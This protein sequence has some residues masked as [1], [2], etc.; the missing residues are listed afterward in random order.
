VTAASV[1][2]RWAEAIA[3]SRALRAIPWVAA[4]VTMTVGWWLW[5]SLNA[6]P[7][8]Y[9]EAAYLLQA[10]IFATFRWATEGRPL[11]EFF[12]QL[13]VF[14]TPKLVPKY[15]PGHAITMVPGI[16]LGLA[17]LVPLLLAGVAAWLICWLAERLTDRVT[18]ILTWLVWLT[19]PTV[20]TFMPS[21][22]S[23]STTLVTWLGGWAC[24]LRWRDDSRPRWLLAGSA[25]LAW[26][27]ITRPFSMIA[28]AVPAGLWLLAALYRRGELRRLIAMALV[29]SAILA[30]PLVWSRSVSGRAYP[31]PYSEYSRV[32]APWNMPGFRIDST[33]PLRPPTVAM[34]VFK[35][36]FLP[37]H[38]SHRIERLPAI[39][40]E[41]L[42]GTAK[43][44]WGPAGWRWLLLPMALLGIFVLP[45]SASIGLGSAALLVLTYLYMAAR[46]RWAIYHLEAV[47]V[48]AL[49]TAAGL[50]WTARMVERSVVRTTRGRRGLAVGLVVVGVLAAIPGSVDR[51][52]RIR[53]GLRSLRAVPER[54]AAVAD[55]IPGPAIVFIRTSSGAERHPSY[56]RNEPDLEKTRV[57]LV[58]DRGDDNERLTRLA[59]DRATFLFDPGSGELLPATMP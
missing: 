42:V 47:P 20:M 3:S 5:G 57:W 31:T 35:E 38:E 15:P 48:A 40:V 6:E 4:A 59:P 41:R 12:E 39:L 34:E 55:S 52:V 1:G 54:L 33:P 37:L 23:Q 17:G 7:W 24:L 8:I 26:G 16:W 22:M 28:F 32:Y 45:R 19:A 44:I 46:P 18:A 50:W 21:Y 53:G 27:A 13:H 29:A 36:G 43:E 51:A 2:P 49:A 25:L 58:E 9:D 14:V 56:L 11:P 30:L 10:K